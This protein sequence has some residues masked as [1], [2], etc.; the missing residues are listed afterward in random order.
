MSIV[1]TGVCDLVLADGERCDPLPYL[2]ER[3]SKKYLGL[4]DALSL[5]SAG[6][7]LQQAGLWG[8]L[9]SERTGL[10]VA[11]GFI[12]FLEADVAPV[13]RHSVDPQGNFD[14]QRF[15]A[16]GYREAHPLLAFRCLPNMPAYHVAAN[17][18]IQG[19][20]LVVYPSAGQLYVALEEATAAL[21][22]ERVD[23]ALVIG[24]AHQKNFL[25]EHHLG[26]CQPAVAAQQLRDAAAALVLERASSPRRA[27]AE[28]CE[29][30]LSYRPFDPLQEMPRLGEEII[31]QP[32]VLE[33][34]PAELGP[35]L[36]IIQLARAVRAGARSFRHQLLSRDGIHGSS[37]WGVPA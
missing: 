9:P 25:V 24:V 14:P 8:S 35:A 33:P 19:P 37:V 20:Y 23:V 30:T 29:L 27:L 36:P 10:Y 11:V 22:E 6:R 31:T 34:E 17:C 16:E 5:V 2:A 13:L 15:A 21:A 3:K 18:N 12:P 28:L 32:R 1:A 26:R 7:A 4:Q